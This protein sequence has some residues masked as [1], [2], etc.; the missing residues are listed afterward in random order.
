M[1]P[2]EWIAFEHADIGTVLQGFR[3]LAQ[4]GIRNNLPLGVTGPAPPEYLAGGGNH[5]FQKVIDGLF[6]GVITVAVIVPYA[7]LPTAW[8]VRARF[9]SQIADPTVI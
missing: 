9:V 6:I 2:L 1:P 8:S 4:R 5:P 3:A 7:D